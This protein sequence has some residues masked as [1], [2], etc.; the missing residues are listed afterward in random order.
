[1]TILSIVDALKLVQNGVTTVAAIVRA[2][3]GQSLTVRDDVSDLTAEQV[4][5]HL[6]RAIGAQVEAST[7]AGERIDRRHGGG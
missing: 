7:H 4:E 6:V 2:I 3:R 5:E 1:M